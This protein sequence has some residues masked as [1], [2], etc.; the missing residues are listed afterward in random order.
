MDLS[1]LEGQLR[2]CY[3]RVVYTHKTHEKCADLLLDKLKKMK[4]LQLVLLAITTGS[5]I[6]TVIGDAKTGAII[7]SILS[8]ILLFINTYLKDYDLGTLA[9]KHRQAA[10]EI[11]LIREKYLSLLTDLKL[12]TK[13]IEEITKERDKLMNELSTI[14]AGAPSTNYKAYSMA[15]KAL[16]ELEDMT[17]SDEEIDKFLPSELKRK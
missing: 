7:G 15:Q 14:Y 12:Q 13:E 6:S 8:A 17:F 11:W 9:Q 5:F 16:K 1:V 3:G 2:E 10:S 4:N